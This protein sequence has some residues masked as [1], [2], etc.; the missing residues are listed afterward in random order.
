[1]N[2]VAHR[3]LSSVIGWDEFLP[4]LDRLRFW[5]VVVWLKKNLWWWRWLCFFGKWRGGECLSAPVCGGLR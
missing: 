3:F 1:M 5:M 4:L 2:E